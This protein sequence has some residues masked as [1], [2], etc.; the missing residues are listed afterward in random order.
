VSWEPFRRGIDKSQHLQYQ[1]LRDYYLQC[2]KVDF[3]YYD[4]ICILSEIPAFESSREHVEFL[5]LLFSRCFFEMS[6]LHV[7]TQKTL[8]KSRS[9]N[10]LI[11]CIKRQT[12]TLYGKIKSGWEA[13]CEKM[14]KQESEIINLVFDKFSKFFNGSNFKRRDE[15]LTGIEGPDFTKEEQI[16]FTVKMYSE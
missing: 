7:I 10:V 3:V 8:F 6:Q 4:I 12:V 16:E 1:Q 14:E 15:L 13:I 9:Q 5:Y 11:A 2:L